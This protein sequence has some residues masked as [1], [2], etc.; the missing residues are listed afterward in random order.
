MRG[1][2]RDEAKLALSHARSDCLGMRIGD[3][4]VSNVPPPN[5]DVCGGERGLIH[6]LL[7]QI[8]ARGLNSDPWQRAKVRGDSFTEKLVPV[9]LFL[10]WLLFVPD[11]DANWFGHGGLEL[12]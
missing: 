3:R 12:M 2:Q 7:R 8:Q 5:E 6:T 4:A 1:M 11:K 10:F 9:C